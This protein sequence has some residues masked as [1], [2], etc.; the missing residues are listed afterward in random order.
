MPSR[1]GRRWMGRLPTQV[2]HTRNSVMRTSRRTIFALLLGAIPLAPA[3]GFDGSPANV[4]PPVA[5]DTAIGVVAP[6]PK[7]LSNRPVPPAAIPNAGVP[8]ANVPGASV[9]STALATPG[10]TNS[11]SLTSL[12]Y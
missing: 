8:S 5:K 7:A 10:V 3:Y 6:Q 11:S 2:A 12:Q 9:T 1:L 4:P